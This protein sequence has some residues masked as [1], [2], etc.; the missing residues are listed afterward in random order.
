MRK[1]PYGFEPTAYEPIDARIIL[2][3]AQMKDIIGDE[4]AGSDFAMPEVYFALCIDDG[5]WYRFDYGFDEEG[6]PTRTPDPETGYFTKMEL[7]GSTPAPGSGTTADMAAALGDANPGDEFYNTDNKILYVC[8]ED[9]EGTKAWVEKQP[10]IGEMMYDQTS[11]KILYYDGEQWKEVGGTDVV[12]TT[13]P[14]SPQVGDHWLDTTV[15]PPVEKVW[16]GTQ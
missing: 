7:G 12:P 5:Q 8:E 1:V 15:T 13:E 10:A 11:G 4:A 2:T 3:K 6:N 9:S 16:D 14:L